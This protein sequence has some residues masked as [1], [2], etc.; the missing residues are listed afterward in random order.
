M[1]SRAKRIIK[2]YVV[3]VLVT[4]LTRSPALLLE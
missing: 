3:C 2:R 1:L 4:I